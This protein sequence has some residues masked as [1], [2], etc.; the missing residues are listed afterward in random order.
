MT[1]TF[2]RTAVLFLLIVAGSASVVAAQGVGIKVGPT[3]ADFNSEAL[4]FDTRTGWHLGLF[5]GGNS[6]GVVGVQ[7]EVNW[8]RKQVEQPLEARD[9]RIDYLQLPVLL[10]VNI[11]GNSASA[12]RVF[13]VGGAGVNIKI[14]DEIEGVTIDDGFEGADVPLL[15]GGGIEAA[16]IIVEGRYEKGFRRINKV[17][18][19]FTEVKSQS[20]TIL[21]GVRFR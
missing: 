9:I 14:G 13:A 3:F 1:T 8:I 4:D 11:G 12:F 2:F 7:G 18:S 6:D 5:F 16:R 15:F 19:D 21:F 10:R 20:F 17:F